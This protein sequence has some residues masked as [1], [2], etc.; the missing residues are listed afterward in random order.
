MNVKK[1]RIIAY[2]LAPFSKDIAPQHKKKIDFILK[3]KYTTISY[4]QL[5]HFLINE[6]IDGNNMSHRKR[7]HDNIFGGAG[8]DGQMFVDEIS[9][10]ICKTLHSGEAWSVHC[11]RTLFAWIIKNGI[12]IYSGNTLI[13]EGIDEFMNILRTH[14]I[15]FGR[16]A[17]VEVLTRGLVPIAIKKQTDFAPLPKVV[18]DGGRIRQRYDQSIEGFVYEYIRSGIASGKAENPFSSQ[19]ETKPDPHVYVLAGFGYDPDVSGRIQ[20]PLSSLIKEKFFLDK[21]DEYVMR[22]ERKKLQPVI[23]TEVPTFEGDGF[24]RDGKGLQLMNRDYA[25][26]EHVSKLYRNSSV[27]EQT[28]QFNSLIN[29]DFL[30]QDP[31]SRVDSYSGF[32]DINGAEPPPRITPL[33]VGHK[34]ARVDN[35][36]ARSD[37]LQMKERFEK[38]ISNAYGIPHSILSAEGRVMSGIK[39][40]EQ[41]FHESLRF[42]RTILAEIFSRAFQ[43]IY[44]TD[45]LEETVTSLLET[46]PREKLNKPVLKEALLNRKITFEFP[47]ETTDTNEELIS[48]W[49]HGIISWDQYVSLSLRSS[50]ISK[51]STDQVTTDPWSK[52]ERLAFLNI[53]K[54]DKDKSSSSTQ[55]EKK[56]K[57][58][59]SQDKK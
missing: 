1:K 6:I 57:K 7:K 48:K 55:S 46:V 9:A 29:D 54:K 3:L 28:R 10:N 56:E 11:W 38:L 39:L 16:D 2:S 35:P 52:D 18:K 32:T 42:W 50:G 47:M 21:M 59:K 45:Q 8:N 34:I 5:S 12:N 41:V 30:N 51:T 33:P 13:T 17:L 24:G 27:V 31:S 36:Q 49:V 44:E 20:S 58:E 23:V 37:W 4:I 43:M 14:W 40:N 25:T 53:G 15:P 22:M 26:A 19:M